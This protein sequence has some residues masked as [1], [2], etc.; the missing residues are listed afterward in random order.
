MYVC[1]CVCVCMCVCLCVYVCVYVYVCMYVCVYVCVC[2][3]VGIIV[4]SA[5]F[6][7]KSCIFLFILGYRALRFLCRRF[8]PF[9]ADQFVVDIVDGFG[10]GRVWPV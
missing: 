10:C 9:C 7:F 2:V 8:L 6:F 3:W 5:S 1:V 4:S